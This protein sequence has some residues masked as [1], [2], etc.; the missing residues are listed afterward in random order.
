MLQNT[1]GLEP[2]GRAV[3]VEMYEPEKRKGLIEIPELVKERSSVMEQRAMVVAIGGQAWEDEGP[4]WKRFLGI[5]T[6][7]ARP[8]DKVI[9]TKFAGYVTRGTSDNR[10]YRLVNDRDI[11]CRIVSEKDFSNG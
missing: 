5:R 8:G 2:S 10:L 9:V 4:L 6:L 3:L 7:R 1:S 11:F